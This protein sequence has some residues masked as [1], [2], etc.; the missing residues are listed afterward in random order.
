MSSVAEPDGPRRRPHRAVSASRKDNI[1]LARLMTAPHGRTVLELVE[2]LRGES[3]WATR[4]NVYASVQRLVRRGLA[5]RQMTPQGYL[6]AA[7]APDP[8][9]PL[10]AAFA[11]AP[12]PEHGPPT[13][14]A[15]DR[16]HK[17]RRDRYTHDE[18][19]AAI[20]RWADDHDE[21]PAQAD[22]NPA[23]L[24]R[25]ARVMAAKAVGH[26]Q[27]IAEYDS[28][29]W[30]S[31]TTVVKYFGS[32][33]AALAAAGFGAIL[34]SSGNQPRESDLTL[35]P[36]VGQANKIEQ[37]LSTV[38]LA[39]HE[40]DRH[41]LRSSLLDLSLVARDWAMRISRDPRPDPAQP[42]FPSMP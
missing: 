19:I 34:R 14:N 42:S 23:L 3:A 38:I 29:D 4:D 11:A 5:V 2:R 1:V 33:N 16:T 28:G 20:L 30:P 24:R 31:S 26:L 39:H 21:P 7:I 18:I 13:V 22:W 15:S 32:W 10:E 37:L 6:Y 8:D 35:V 27:R 36:G 9:D 17:N 12:A 41:G 40:N 25:H